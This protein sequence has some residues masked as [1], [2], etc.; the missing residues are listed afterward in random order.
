MADDEL[1]WLPS[2]FFLPHLEKHLPT[3]FFIDA[4]LHSKAVALSQ[5]FA[6]EQWR[7]EKIEEKVASKVLR[8][9]M[10]T[11]AFVYCEIG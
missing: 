7:K 2:R 8:S 4:R 10:I 6:Y 5:P 11:T 1:C 3:G 9:Q